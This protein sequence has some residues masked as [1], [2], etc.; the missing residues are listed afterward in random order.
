MDDMEDD[1]TPKELSDALVTVIRARR[2]TLGISS[3]EIARRI[4]AN[5][6]YVS[7]RIDGGNPRTGSLIPLDV[8][9]LAAFAG[10]LDLTLGELLELAITE[11]SSGR[12]GDDE[13]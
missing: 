7:S 4:G 8:R 6:Q 3:R 2:D 10:A 1:F 12:V 5:A 13:R 11:T 9:D